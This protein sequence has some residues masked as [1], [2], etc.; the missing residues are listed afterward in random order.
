MLNAHVQNGDCCA[1]AVTYQNYLLKKTLVCMWVFIVMAFEGY[2]KQA[3]TYYELVIDVRATS[4]CGWCEMK[5]EYNH[6]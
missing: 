3:V 4:G 6:N 1:L 5:E 2:T